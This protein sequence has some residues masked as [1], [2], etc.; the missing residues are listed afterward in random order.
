MLKLRAWLRAAGQL[1]RAG[2]VKLGS[3]LRA[4]G[5]P[6]GEVRRTIARYSQ[7]NPKTTVGLIVVVA[8][9]PLSGRWKQFVAALSSWSSRFGNYVL[10]LSQAHPHIARIVHVIL[11]AVPDAVPLLLGLAGL[12]YIMPDLTKR[13]E[14]HKPTRI[15]LGVTVVAISF[16]AVAVNAVNR[17]AQE[18]K[19]EAQGT[20]MSDLGN[21]VIVV[22][23][24][25]TQ[26]ANFLLGSKGQVSEADRRKGIETVLRNGYRLSHDPID[27]EIVAGNKMPPADW[28]NQRLKEMGENWQFVNHDNAPSVAPR[29]PPKVIVIKSTPAS[30]PSKAGEEAKIELKI[31]V[32]HNGPMLVTAYS[33]GGVKPIDSDAARQMQIEDSLWT[34]MARQPKGLPVQMPSGNETL[35]IPIKFEGITELDF[36]Q[37]KAG[38][39]EYYFMCHVVDARETTLLDFCGHVDAKGNLTYCRNHNGP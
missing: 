19:E 34:I 25:N 2:M 36:A 30:L 38:T 23:G 5:Q 35:S 11:N 15:V 22:Q 26:L 8:L 28:M 17:E 32:N 27:P 39:F 20:A 14:K 9:M 33:L 16:F 24:Q 1:V 21:K 12:G 6:V 3:W 10:Q 4:A 29:N 31:E 18:H 13:I 37:A 7:H